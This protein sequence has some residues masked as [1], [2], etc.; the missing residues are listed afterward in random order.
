MSLEGIP[1]PSNDGVAGVASGAG[2]ST[3]I[4]GALVSLGA[5]PSTGVNGTCG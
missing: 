2:A 1:L 3:G 5:C 4:A